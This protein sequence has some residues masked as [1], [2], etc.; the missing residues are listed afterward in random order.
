M[1]FKMFKNILIVYSEKVSETHLDVVGKIKKIV[2][3]LYSC[4]SVKSTDLQA[5][6]FNNIDLVLTAGGDGTFIRASHFLKNTPILG[7][8]SELKVSEGA[9]TSISEEELEILKEILSG[10]YKII[11]RQR[12]KVARNNVILDKLALNDVYVGSLNQFHTS[13]Y[14]INF[15]GEEEEQ[16]S[17][18]VLI[19]SGSGSN[20]WYKSAGGQPFSFKE[21]KLKFLVREPFTGRIF[22]P[23]ILEGE[24]LENEKIVVKSR[25]YNG[26]VIALDSDSKYDFNLGDV[27][28]IQLSEH[29]L[30]VVVRE[31]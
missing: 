10:K 7:V 22:K 4:K 15:K 28:E 29:P 6:L 9:L 30:N 11:Q 12:A 3:E 23:K 25:R 19:S 27:V 5:S 21:K 20:A 18:G 16:R 17:S 31:D 26:G 24:I 13:K 8:N 14:I 2:E 1:G